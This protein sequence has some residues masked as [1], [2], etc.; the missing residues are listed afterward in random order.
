MGERLGRRQEASNK[1]LRP[2]TQVLGHSLGSKGPRLLGLCVPPST[3]FQ[4]NP[5][6]DSEARIARSRGSGASSMLLLKGPGL[7]GPGLGGA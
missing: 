2:L 4:D 7:R 6:L 5:H 3:L 1:A